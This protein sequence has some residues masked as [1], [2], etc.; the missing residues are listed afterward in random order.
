M[1]QAAA[2]RE[3]CG[4]CSSQWSPP[5]ESWQDPAPVVG[6]SSHTAE[7]G[8]L[9]TS[10]LHGTAPWQ[11][12]ACHWPNNSPSLATLSGFSLLTNVPPHEHV[13]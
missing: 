10:A 1:T 13:T 11:F 9:H 3:K 4:T 12:C 5:D 8:G 7:G 2:T 6:S